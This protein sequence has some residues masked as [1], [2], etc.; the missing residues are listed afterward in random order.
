MGGAAGVPASLP[1]EGGR[2][3]SSKGEL[4]HSGCTKVTKSLCVC[5]GNIHISLSFSESF[6]DF[7]LTDCVSQQRFF[8]IL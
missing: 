8:S 3:E 5:G 4:N 1:L 7:F 6:Q 2:S